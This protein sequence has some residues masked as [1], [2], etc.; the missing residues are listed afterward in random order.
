MAG[1]GSTA[2][3]LPARILAAVAAALLG[4]IL[5]VSPWGQ[6]LGHL[7]YDLQ[8]A[9]R[10]PVPPPAEVVV[11]AIDEPSMGL[12]GRQW[13]WP[14]SLHAR[15][16]DTL[17]AAG[18]RAV[19]LDII[20]AEPSDPAEDAALA[21]ALAAHGGLLLG[22]ELEVIRDASYEQ[23]IFVDPATVLGADPNRVALVN[24]PVDGDGFVR[25]APRR[26][27]GRVGFASRAAEMFRGEAVAS[28][29]AT[30]Q[31]E[32]WINFVGPPRSIRSVSYYQA[33]EP[34]RHL[35]DGF[36]RDKL[37]FVGLAAEGTVDANRP[38]PDHYPVPL[39]RAGHGYMAG[40]EIHAQTA[41]TLLAGTELRRPAAYL[42]PLLGLLVGFFST[43]LFLRWKPWLGAL[44][45][46]AEVGILVALTLVLFERRF[47][48]LPLVPILLPILLGYL[49][50]PFVHYRSTWKERRFIRQTFSTYLA[51]P[52]VDQ[53]LEDPQR[54]RLG[55]EEMEATV[56]FLDLAGFTSF[57]EKLDPETLVALLNRSLGRLGE[58]VFAHRGMVDKYIG[59]CVM[60]L[61]G[62]PLPL[63]DH[64]RRASLAALDIR[65]AMRE[66]AAREQELTGVEL[67]ARIGI[68]SGPV[69]AGNL[70]GGQHVNYTAL[71][72]HVNL[73]ARLEGA[74]K[75]YG[76]SIL[77]SGSTAAEAGE[78]LAL[79]ELDT[80]IVRGQSVAVTIF[81]LQGRRDELDARQRE[82]NAA[83]AEGLRSYRQMRWD[84]A[85]AALRRAL[86]AVPD[87]G[88]S[89]LLLDRC[90]EFAS[91][92]P[93]ADWQGVF[94]LS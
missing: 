20:F 29:A 70:G 28:L 8:F 9:L 43:V 88:P 14:R 79:R 18:A 25:R 81:E 83:Y 90:G 55:G 12:V 53:L 92:P 62:V 94:R 74:N 84:E 19:A 17:F 13:P 37:V 54:L 51:A 64:A 34:D 32:I 38:T 45:V 46:I 93:P 77:L 91:Q 50:S 16:A 82:V 61:W 69:I 27:E 48:V 5:A 56:F 86:E 11:V 58:I 2:V 39:T 30:G 63:P 6:G 47:F 66:L 42:G 60:A 35:P 80:V 44:L 36:F 59:D 41:W 21:A 65:A 7:I 75:L 23:R 72:S 3:P 73:A 52:V 76:T 71:G 67:H 15:L 10:G 89:A 78:D 40:V 87:D 57:S 22:S 24:L 31:G 85:A 33:L 49:F 26:L 4:V 68:N 1:P